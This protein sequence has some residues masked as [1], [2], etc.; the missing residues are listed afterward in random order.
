MKS[1]DVVVIGA[2]F[3]GITAA[4][5]LGNAGKRVVVL[6]ARDRIGGRTWLE[7]RMGKQLE[8][9]GTWVHWTQPFVWAELTRYGIG[10]IQS[11][12]PTR[13]WWFPNDHAIEIDP[14]DLIQKMDAANRALTAEARVYFEDPYKPLAHPALK[15]VDELTV[16]QKLDAIEMDDDV[17]TLMESFWSLNFN[18]SIDDGA[19]TQALRWAALTNGDWAVNFEACATYKIAG[20]TKTLI[21][22]MASDVRGE[23]IFNS[24]VQ[25]IDSTGE[26]VLVTT[27]GGEVFAA[28][29]VIETVGIRAIKSI[30]FTPPVAPSIQSAIDLGQTALG[31]KVWIKV[32]GPVEPFVAFGKS[33]W[34]L[35]FFQ[36]DVETTDGNRLLIAFG[37]AQ[38]RIDPLDKDSVA[39]ELHRLR[40]D[41]EVL[42]VAAHDWV[43]DEWSQQTWS[44]HKPGFLS[45]CLADIQA[46]DGRVI[47]AGSDFANGWSAFFDGAIETGLTSARAVIAKHPT[48]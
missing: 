44:M 35:N 34:A 36:A 38:S 45:S 27:R 46:T 39:A 41:L 23:I 43:N 29:S 8:L 19:Y 20:G 3:A 25:A 40:P 22:A 2:G 11:P 6:E 1:V 32:R 15:T 16:K 28:D 7:E 13:A 48:T 47:H 10:T 18:G 5:E 33:D 42:E 14:D 30:E 26:K 4:R 12:I 24:P 9:G 17:R 31:T 21:D 37:P